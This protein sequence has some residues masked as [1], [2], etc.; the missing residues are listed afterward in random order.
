MA[1]QVFVSTAPNSNRFFIPFLISGHFWD[2]CVHHI[3][4]NDLKDRDSKMSR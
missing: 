2:I 3:T 1:L 4:K